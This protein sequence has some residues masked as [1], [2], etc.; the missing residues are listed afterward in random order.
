MDRA[1]LSSLVENK[2]G[3]GYRKERPHNQS[4]CRQLN[5]GRGQGE[6]LGRHTGGTGG[7]QY[8]SVLLLTSNCDCHAPFLLM[9]EE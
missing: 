2:E 6:A 5:H 4:A 9:L 7:A 8:K 3:M 1:L